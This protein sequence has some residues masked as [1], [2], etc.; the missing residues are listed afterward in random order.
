MGYF[1]APSEAKC[2]P[3]S[4]ALASC[5]AAR[6]TRRGTG[7][8]AVNARLPGDLTSTFTMASILRPLHRPPRIYAL[9]LCTA[10]STAVP[11]VR[12]AILTCSRLPSSRSLKT[13]SAARNT[14]SVAAGLPK[15]EAPTPPEAASVGEEKMYYGPLAQTF[16]R[17]KIFSVSSLAITCVMTPFLFLIE[18]ASAVPL[19]ELTPRSI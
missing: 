18:T 12:L 11:S 1:F 13:S 2:V 5:L 8:G 16:R 14:P 7:T 15:T 10:R 17:L 9:G 6:Q 19:R 3:D 4:D